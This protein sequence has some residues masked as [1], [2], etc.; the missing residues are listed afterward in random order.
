MKYRVVF[1]SSSKVKYFDTIAFY[2]FLA[3][4]EHVICYFLIYR[5]KVVNFLSLNDFL[6]I[7]LIN[8]DLFHVADT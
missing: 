2:T 4:Q 1:E 8:K 6:S 5:I 7:F 3:I